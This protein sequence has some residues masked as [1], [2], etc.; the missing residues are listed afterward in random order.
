[1]GQT[2]KAAAK[3][4]SPDKK[5]KGGETVC[6]PQLL[7]LDANQK[8]LWFNGGLF[9]NKFAE[10]SE[11]VFGQFDDYIVERPKASYT[12]DWEMQSN[13]EVCLTESSQ[14]KR[15]FSADEKATL[16]KMI[17]HAKKYL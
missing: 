2:A 16:D 6:S 11:W 4:A 3:T 10:R 7:H 17:S 15:S 5:S 8:P 14:W 1:M 12:E 13:N 9:K